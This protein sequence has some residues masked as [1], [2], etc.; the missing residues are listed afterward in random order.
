MMNPYQVLGVPVGADEDTVKKAYKRLAKL[1]HPDLGGDGEKFK[2]VNEA[3]E[4]IT[5]GS[6][7]IEMPKHHNLRHKTLFTFQFV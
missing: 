7:V 4:A 5:K 3:Y 1:H 2:E 6:Y